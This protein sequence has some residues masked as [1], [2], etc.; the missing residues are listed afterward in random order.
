MLSPAVRATA[1]PRTRAVTSISAVAATRGGERGSRRGNA[2]G[3]GSAEPSPAARL[4][5]QVRLLGPLTIS[6]D[7]VALALPA[8]RKVRALLAYLALA[9]HAVRAQPAVRAA[10]GRS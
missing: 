8:S 2:R 3:I 5:L 1:G 4:G 9:P 7:G 10:V 6:R